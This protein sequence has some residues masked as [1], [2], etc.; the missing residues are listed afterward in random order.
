MSSENPFEAP[1]SDPDPR[2]P[3]AV[4]EGDLYAPCPRC[5][6]RDA[7]PVGFTWWGGAIG[8][9]MLTHVK[10]QGCG[11]AYNGKTGRSNTTGIIIY[12]AVAFGIA[13]AIYV[14]FQL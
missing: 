8:G 1:Q 6:R 9:K 5:Q 7:H 14:L 4:V 2:P 10:C 11:Y 12:Q 3:A 13:I